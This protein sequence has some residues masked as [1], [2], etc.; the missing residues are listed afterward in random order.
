MQALRSVWVSQYVMLFYWSPVW[1]ACGIGA[2]F[3]LAQ[4]PG[5]STYIIAGI[6]LTLALLLICKTYLGRGFI[7]AFAML[8]FGFVLAGL[9]AHLVAGPVLQGHYYGPI[10]GRIVTIDRSASDKLRLTLD[11]V[12]LRGIS[13]ESTPGRVRIALHGVSEEN[14]KLSLGQI[15]MTTGYLSPPAGRVEPQGFDFRRHAWFAR[16][17]AQG[18]TR[19][20]VLRMKADEIGWLGRLR[21]DLSDRISAAMPMRTGGFANALLTGD[22]SGLGKDMVEDLRHSNLAHLLAISGLHMGLVAGLV[23]ASIRFGLALWPAIALRVPV[24]KVAALGALMVAAFYL[25]LSGGAVATTRA[26]IMAAVALVAILFD[27][28][29]LTLRSVA[30]AA[31]IVL[32]ITPE[33]LL[34]P[35][36]QMSFAATTALVAAF[37][38]ISEYD[39]PM[40]PRWARPIVTLFISSFF[41]GLATAPFA[42]AHFNHIATYGLIANLLAVPFMGLLIMPA[43]IIAVV[44][45]P[46]GVE[47]L[48]LWVMGKG[49]EWILWVAHSIAELP[50]SRRMVVQPDWY[51]LP[52]LS[53]GALLGLLWQGRGGRWVGVMVVIGSCAFWARTERPTIMISEGGG[54]VGVMT[55][56]G[57]AL[58]TAKG[59]GFAAKLWLENDGDGADQTSAAGRWALIDWQHRPSIIPI[60]GKRAAQEITD[61]P[62]D[63]LVITSSAL[64][65]TLPCDTLGPQHLSRSGSLEIQWDGR[66]WRRI[67]TEQRRLWTPK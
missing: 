12:L 29:A 52:M 53:F 50:G 31:L 65:Q 33:S 64:P 58:S 17:G 38:M 30:I 66:E 47:H 25:H 3:S 37:A 35:G 42:A 20:P 9:R 34:S 67:G 51:V 4:E 57:R 44:M 28:R 10:S 41:A 14:P 62:K 18:Y 54:L 49:L 48:P 63:A 22:R 46:F 1:L 43:G 60:R 45:T 16:I 7:C 21:R 24:Q 19:V 23:F 8:I 61:C 55:S 5:Q 2:Y 15:I 27:R 11:K 56:E 59:D 36:F 26:F 39:L 13:L 40:G 6:L 32:I